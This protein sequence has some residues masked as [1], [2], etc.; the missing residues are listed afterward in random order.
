M[1]VCHMRSL[2]LFAIVSL[3]EARHA[4]A[5]E[6]A[7]PQEPISPANAAT[8]VPLN[9]VLFFDTTLLPASQITLSPAVA[10]TTQQHG[11]YLVAKPSAQLAAHTTYTVSWVVEGMT[12]HSTFTTGNATLTTP[13]AFPG[14]ASIAPETMEM[15][16]T[17]TSSGGV[18][19]TC[20]IVSANGRISR[21][22]L[23]FPDPPGAVVLLDLQVV[24]DGDAPPLL[25]E[26]G[27]K[28]EWLS[29]RLLGFHSCV[30]TAPALDPGASYCVRVTAFDAAGN[31]AGG[32]KVACSAAAIC[33]PMLDQTSCAPAD[34]CNPMGMGPGSD[35][36][37]G[38][39]HGG[40][41]SAPGAGVA[42]LLLALLPLLARANR[43]RRVLG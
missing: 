4:D 18:C 11:T 42:L 35:P 24:P 10:V 21:I 20:G 37:N 23:D 16:S 39:A 25:L 5:C 31:S 36:G 2:L 41:D 19:G 13:P 1:A 22:H 34:A 40:C 17:M 14:I 7:F 32:D 43:L 9:A 27:M 29:D 3:L 28:P 15:P 26:A 8:E 6:C 30:P 38:V 33:E 12:Q